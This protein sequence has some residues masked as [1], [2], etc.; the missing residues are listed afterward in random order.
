MKTKLFLLKHNIFLYIFS[1]ILISSVFNQY[2]AYQGVLPVDSFSTFNSGYDI[3]N[4]SVP[5]KDYWVL[6]GIILDFIQAGFF[7]VFG[8]S[9]FSYAL[10]SSTFNSIFA[11]A[12]FYTLRELGLET[13]YAFIYSVASSVLMYPTYGTP[14]T[15]HS[16][17]IFCIL[18]VYSLILSIKNKNKIFWFLIPILLFLAFFTKQTPSG[19][20]TILISFISILFLINN[21]DKK[22]I[23]YGLLGSFIPV[24]T[25][26][27]YIFYKDISL[28]SIYLQYFLYP[29]SLGETRL[30]WLLPIEFQR[31]V[32]RHKLI[33]LALA[34]PFYFLIK[35]IYKNF[36]SIIEIDNLIFL[37]LIGTLFI[38][39]TH[40]LMTINGLYIF[41]LI[42]VFS[43]FSHIYS[44]KIKKNKL[45]INFFLILSLV[46]SIY[47]HQKYISKRDT[48]ILRDINLNDAVNAGKLSKKLENLKWI[49][50]HYPKNP[51]KE[52]ENLLKSIEI[53]K[54]DK[55]K[56]MIVT[57]YQFISV[58]L[59]L[60][61]N[62]AARIW[63]RHH[64]YPQSG[65]KYFN[66]WKSFLLSKIKEKNIKVI[67]TVHPLEGEHDI[68]EGLIKSNC[69]HKE[70]LN[71]IL[72]IQRLQNC[73]ELNSFK[74]VKNNIN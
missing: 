55:Q 18:A 24:I 41:F 6:K 4:G 36:L 39:V 74:I 44:K 54:S 25:G 5:F 71:E 38:F 28:E 35:N 1:L 50:H 12:T 43:G 56:K 20:I 47:Y 7:K 3:L 66:K 57:D 27:I 31:F 42:P 32:L 33:Y 34:V 68:F 58:I 19:Y 13:K 69:I 8:V 40:Q 60:D 10:H 16:T 21:F 48:L 52:I 63:W 37:T 67:Y 9:W 64:I 46:S 22:I 72:V 49:T 62:A 11:L 29:I 45:L 17:A 23:Y 14:F 53:I 51:E 70:K 73:K 65:Q 61:D 2:Y 15:D 30:E 26:L 59:N